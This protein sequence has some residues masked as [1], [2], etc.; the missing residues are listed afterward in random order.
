[1]AG[2]SEILLLDEPLAHLDAAL[3]EEVASSIVASAR[4]MTATVLHVT[5]DPADAMNLADRV[6][7]VE[8]GRVTQVDVPSELLARPATRFTATVLGHINII[9]S[10]HTGRPGAKLRANCRL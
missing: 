10:L 4:T 8:N 5:H 3:R 1:L 2:G 9:A 7:V 6:A